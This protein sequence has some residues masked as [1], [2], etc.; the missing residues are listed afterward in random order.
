MA[1]AV[2]M[3]AFFRGLGQTLGIAIGGNI[4]QKYVEVHP[5]TMCARTVLTCIS[6]LSSKLADQPEFSAKASELAK[7]ATALVHWMQNEPPGQELDVMRTAFTE[8][9]RVVYIAMAAAALVATLASLW[10]K[11]HD[12]NQALETEQGLTEAGAGARTEAKRRPSGELAMEEMDRALE[13]ALGA[14]RETSR[15]VAMYSGV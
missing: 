5:L 9:M 12:I 3:F 13:A 10:I 4:F 2:A 6:V 14:R 15:S 11:H 7:E 8:S 1:S